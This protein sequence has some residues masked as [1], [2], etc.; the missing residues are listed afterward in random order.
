MLLTSHSTPQLGQWDDLDYLL[1]PDAFVSLSEAGAFTPGTLHDVK[2]QI[3][4]E[5]RREESVWGG[6]VIV[7]LCSF[8]WQ[9]QNQQ[10]PPQTWAEGST[11]C[12]GACAR[13]IPETGWQASHA[14]SLSSLAFWCLSR[15][16][17]LLRWNRWLSG[18]ASAHSRQEQQWLIGWNMRI[19]G[20][21]YFI[22][23]Y[24]HWRIMY[25]S[26]ILKHMS[27]LSTYI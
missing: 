10:T 22:K 5:T 27:T 8:P 9:F 15:L 17:L 24:A 14:H 21:L 20:Y 1:Q 23:F 2:Q 18:P 6:V 26:Q 16:E 3:Y 4:Y 12:H 7:P 25:H 13:C 19:N 11:A